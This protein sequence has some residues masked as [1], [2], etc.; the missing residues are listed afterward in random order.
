V[1]SAVV[2]IVGAT[3][4]RMLV[5]STRG[6]YFDAGFVTGGLWGTTRR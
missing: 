5:A 2:V 1:L 6:A 3:M 4:L